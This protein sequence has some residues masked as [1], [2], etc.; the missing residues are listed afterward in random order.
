MIANGNVLW[1]L[2]IDVSV[3]EF[4]MENEKRGG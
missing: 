3:E 4:V 1:C 2:M